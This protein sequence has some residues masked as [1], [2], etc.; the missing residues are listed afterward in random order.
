MTFLVELEIGF[1]EGCE[2]K[3]CLQQEGQFI[4]LEIMLLLFM[5]FHRLQ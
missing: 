2:V 5:N 4:I 1:C 3:T